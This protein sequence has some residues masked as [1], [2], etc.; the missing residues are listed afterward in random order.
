[1]FI[2]PISNCSV[3]SATRA[4][5]SSWKI[6]D[7]CCP[8]GDCFSEVLHSTAVIW[9]WTCHHRLQRG[10]HTRCT[11]AGRDT[12]SEVAQFHFPVHYLSDGVH[13]RGRNVWP[14]DFSR[15][16]WMCLFTYSTTYL[17]PVFLHWGRV[18]LIHPRAQRDVPLAWTLVLM[19]CGEYREY[20]E[21]KT[22]LSAEQRHDSLNQRQHQIWKDTILLG[23]KCCANI[24]PSL[25]PSWSGLHW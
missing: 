6:C 18:R 1:M 17:P 20:E 2:I 11:C 3:E 21:L 7:C 9:G 10:A 25:F 15:N 24:N 19:E 13:W 12:V 4:P 8:P 5:L 16:D 14:C 22:T 23:Y